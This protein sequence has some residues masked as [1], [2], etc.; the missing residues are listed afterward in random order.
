MVEKYTI[1]I[2]PPHIWMLSSDWLIKEMFSTISEFFPLFHHRTG[3]CPWEFRIA[4]YLPK[5]MWLGKF[6]SPLN[7]YFLQITLTNWIYL[8][9]IAVTPVERVMLFVLM[10]EGTSHNARY[11]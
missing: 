8:Y 10:Y 3:I 5:L 7:R 9:N 2:I 4:W 6:A 11:R 1:A